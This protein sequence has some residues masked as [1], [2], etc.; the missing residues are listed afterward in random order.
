MDILN[1]ERF[2]KLQRIL[3]VALG[4][5]LLYAGVLLATAPAFR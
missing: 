2:C 3:M 1:Q 5:A 4:I